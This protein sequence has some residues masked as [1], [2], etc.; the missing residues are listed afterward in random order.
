[1]HVAETAPASESRFALLYTTQPEITASPTMLVSDYITAGL[2]E[3]P[4]AA[5]LDGQL[6]AMA[7]LAQAPTAQ[8]E[9]AFAEHVD[10]CGYR[11][12]A[13]LLGLVNY[14]LEQMRAAN[15]RGKPGRRHLP[16]RVRLAGGPAPGTGQARSRPGCRQDST[17]STPAARP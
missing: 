1:M 7:V 16:G 4:Q 3:L 8:L 10:L 5:G 15:Q 14:Q 9:R 6:A 2:S 17:R 11:Y 12:D 13:W